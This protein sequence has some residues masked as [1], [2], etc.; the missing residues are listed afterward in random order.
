M[1]L[2]TLFP[3]LIL[4]GL[5]LALA[6]G[7]RLAEGNGLI[8]GET[9]RRGVQVAIGLILAGFANRMP[10]QIRRWRGAAADAREQRALR[11]G[12]WSL[13]LAGLV[14]AALWAFAPLAV[15]DTLAMA[16]VATA[17]LITLGY[18]L[19]AMVLCRAADTGSAHS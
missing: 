18:A 13:T 9:A 4:A 6:A 2:K 1:T 3:A 10:K 15:A 14:H 11:V 16:V 5:L 17:T 7:L 12:G 19:W 8:D